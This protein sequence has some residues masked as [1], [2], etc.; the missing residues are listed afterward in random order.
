MQMHHTEQKKSRTDDKTGECL[1]GAE[2]G[3]HRP[4]NKC[5]S[6]TR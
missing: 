4:D 2:Q 3:T 5:S 6:K 1:F